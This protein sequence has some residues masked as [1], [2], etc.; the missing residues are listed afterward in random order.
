MADTVSDTNVSITDIIT[1][2]EK[3]IDILVD[4]EQ[5]TVFTFNE[6]VDEAERAEIWRQVGIETNCSLYELPRI[7]ERL[8]E[9]PR[10]KQ[11]FV[12]LHWV[13]FGENTEGVRDDNG[14]SA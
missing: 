12:F 3:C 10:K 8:Q 11:W 13:L 6:P 4:I 9:V 5:T 7:L 14:D 1:D 2:V